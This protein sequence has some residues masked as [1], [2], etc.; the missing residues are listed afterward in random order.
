LPEPIEERDLDF[1]GDFFA[2][3]WKSPEF[4]PGSTTVRARSP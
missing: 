1:G 2:E 3:F 4:S